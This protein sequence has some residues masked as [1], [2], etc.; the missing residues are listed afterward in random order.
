MSKST[1][2]TRNAE[3]SSMLARSS[4]AESVERRLFRQRA[5]QISSRL[6]AL[7]AIGSA[8]QQAS[9]KRRVCSRESFFGRGEPTHDHM[10]VQEQ[11]KVQVDLCFVLRMA[12]HKS[13][14]SFM[15]SSSAILTLPIHFPSGEDVDRAATG[16]T[17]AIGRPRLVTVMDPPRRLM[18][19]GSARHLALNS[20]T[21]TLRV[22]IKPRTTLCTGHLTSL[23]GR[24][25][26]FTGHKRG[27]AEAPILQR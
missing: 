15:S 7:M 25:P 8:L 4:A 14:R 5:V 3:S 10:G 13:D 1:G 23:R 6:I 26:A 20:V 11:P 24:C 21:V 18:S 16:L 17:F 12:S 2:S 9:R 27:Q 19:S 22:F